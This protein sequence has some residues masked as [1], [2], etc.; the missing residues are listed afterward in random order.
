MVVFEFSS[1]W[2]RVGERAYK[3][4]ETVEVRAVIVPSGMIKTLKE[5]KQ[6]VQ[7]TS[8]FIRPFQRKPTGKSLSICEC[9]GFPSNLMALFD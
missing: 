8:T 7:R 6:I 1:R 5:N 4:G 9:D 3:V 2:R